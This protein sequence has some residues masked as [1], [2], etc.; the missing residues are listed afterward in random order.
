MVV[1]S[2]EVVRALENRGMVLA[3]NA[4][5]DLPVGVIERREAVRAAQS[6]GVLFSEDAA[7]DVQNL[8]N[9]RVRLCSLPIQ[10]PP[11]PKTPKGHLPGIPWPVDA[12]GA[13]HVPL[14]A[15]SGRDA[16]KDVPGSLNV[17]AA[18]RRPCVAPGQAACSCSYGRRS[19]T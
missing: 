1:D 14:E 11:A 6:V 5:P 8:E 3:K 2:S 12:T 17:R 15:G 19:I 18:R 13:L 4:A 16:R 7:L 10:Q 9:E